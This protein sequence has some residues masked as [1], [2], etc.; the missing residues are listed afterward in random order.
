MVKSKHYVNEHLQNFHISSDI[1]NILKP[2]RRGS[3]EQTT[4]VGIMY[5]KK[6]CLHLKGKETCMKIQEVSCSESLVAIYQT[7]QRQIPENC[8]FCAVISLNIV[9]KMWKMFLDTG[10]QFINCFNR[11]RPLSGAKM[12]EIQNNHFRLLN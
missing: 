6:G 1:V 8:K 3:A 5:E 11:I 2:I 12:N 9:A 4:N 7:A 10:T